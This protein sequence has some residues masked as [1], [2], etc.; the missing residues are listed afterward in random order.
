[1]ECQILL[2][3]IEY[4]NLGNEGSPKS[5]SVQVKDEQVQHLLPAPDVQG[6]QLAVYTLVAYSFSACIIW[7]KNAVDMT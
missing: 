6:A 1:M 4:V 2:Q 3:S 7:G 5:S